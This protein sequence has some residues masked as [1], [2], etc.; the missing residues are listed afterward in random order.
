MSL[1]TSGYVYQSIKKKSLNL[2]L[3][4]GI[5]QITNVIVLIINT[6]RKKM[7][8]LLNSMENMGE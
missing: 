1:K 2:R 6:K 3:N 5:R 7:W 4:T 8:P